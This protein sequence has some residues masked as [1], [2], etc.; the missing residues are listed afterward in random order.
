MIIDLHI[1]SKNSDGILSVKEIM[2]LAKIKNISML[3]IT[4]HDSIFYQES[5]SILAKKNGINYISGVE[6]NITFVPN[7][8]YAQKSIFLDFLGYY[9]DPENTQLQ[10]KLE[11]IA[12]YRQERAL[13]IL[14]K[15]NKEL[16]KDQI[17]ELDKEDLLKI[18]NSVDGVFGRP[19]IA[20]YLV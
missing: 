8:D 15:L 19:H 2:D 6:L 20:D 10:N 14:K 18:Q 12:Q 16:K 4:D 3:S 17:T 7:T 1:H 9:Y 11:K 13:K 5:A